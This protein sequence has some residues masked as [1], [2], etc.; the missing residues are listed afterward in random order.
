MTTT[1]WKTLDGIEPWGHAL[2]WKLGIGTTP[3]IQTRTGLRCT[4]CG[5]LDVHDPLPPDAVG[6]F[7]TTL[8][9]T[10]D[11]AHISRME[12]YT[13]GSF[14][15]D[16][17]VSATSRRQIAQAWAQTTMDEL[18]VESRPGFINTQALRELTTSIEPARLTI[19]IGVETSNDQ[20]RATLQKGFSWPAIEEAIQCIAQSGA[21]F[22]AYL[23]LKT[24]DMVS[25]AEAVQDLI[26]STQHLMT[27]CRQYSCNLVIAVQPLTIVQ[28]TG[29]HTQYSQGQLRPPWLYT[30]ALAMSRL[31]TL[32]EYQAVTLLLGND[33]DNFETVLV[34]ANYTP[35]GNLCA[36]SDQC[37]SVLRNVNRSADA[38]REATMQVLRSNCSC[39]EAWLGELSGLVSESSLPL[40]VRA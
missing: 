24:P 8:L 37:R 12:L 6:D 28:G 16:Q 25:D 38:L 14:F 1:P 3:C 36:C 5:F 9:A 31:D 7:V 32:R 18:V 34:P 2:R 4:H 23:L 29:V 35:D 15:D 17:E 40:W 27:V 22:Q 13:S 10:R 30:T 33:D 19:A 20:R 11:T 39:K 26:E 21:T